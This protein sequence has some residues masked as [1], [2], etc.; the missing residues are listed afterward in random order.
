ML[1]NQQIKVLIVDDEQIIREGLRLTIDWEKYGF[2]VIGSASNGEKALLLCEEQSPDLVITDIRMPVMDGLELTK[3]LIA[4]YPKVRIIILSAYDDFKYAQKAISYGASEYLL[5]SELECEHLLML[6]LKAAESIFSERKL[7]MESEQYKL[8][9][10]RHLAE[11]QNNLCWNLLISPQYP[12]EIKGEISRLSMDLREDS[13]LLA[14]VYVERDE[15]AAK[16][17]AF[18]SSGLPCLHP[19]F[20]PS[21]Y[22]LASSANHYIFI[23]NLSAFGQPASGLASS[24]M[25]TPGSDASNAMESLLSSGM[26]AFGEELSANLQSPCSIFYSP[27][28]SGFE[29][30]YQHNE[31]I[32]KYSQ[33]YLF[34]EKP[35]IYLC[36][37]SSL[38]GNPLSVMPIITKYIQFVECGQLSS[39]SGLIHEICSSL[40][41]HMYFPYDVKELLALSCSILE[42]KAANIEESP[43][44]F[45]GSP[46]SGLRESSAR[47]ESIHKSLFKHKKLSS[48]LENYTEWESALLHLIEQSLYPCHSIVKQAIQYIHKHLHEEITLQLIAREIYCNP[49]YLSQVFKK[50][51]HMNFSDFLIQTRLKRAMLLLATTPL[52]IGEIAEQVG[53]PNQSYFSRSFI[54]FAGMQPS[55]YRQ[56]FSGWTV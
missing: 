1:M 28:F 42:E 53:I 37:P 7:Q 44:I 9:F 10:T 47:N 26:A 49:T 12:R 39:A 4:R 6:S 15:A 46:F 2:T 54:R 55:K 18:D 43:R 35:G 11:L 51:V 40:P 34:Y 17:P 30:V 31:A 50:E 41:R 3:E 48:L 36:A 45:P 33:T 29:N 25:H 23:G 32:R 8:Q 24:G 38:P 20:A 5:K 14:H 52:P 13:L 16:C 19:Q 21:G 22:W 56:E 27:V